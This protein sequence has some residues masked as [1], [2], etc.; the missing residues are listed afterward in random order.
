MLMAKYFLRQKNVTS[1]KC[2]CLF[3]GKKNPIKEKKK[4]KQNQLKE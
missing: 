2:Y 1:I 4:G 3:K